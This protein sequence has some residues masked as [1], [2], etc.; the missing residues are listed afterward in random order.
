[1]FSRR[2][3]DVLVG[4]GYIDEEGRSLALARAGE[5]GTPFGRACVELGLVTPST[6]WQALA[7]QV[8]GNPIQLDGRDIDP[9]VL[10]L[11]PAAIALKHRCV[12]VGVRTDIGRGMLLVAVDGPRSAKALEEITFAAGR[13]V[14]LL[15][16]PEE[17]LERTLERCYAPRSVAY[18]ARG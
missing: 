5:S 8:G 18:N 6:L 2:I 4:H 7:L 9:S 17:A 12:P 3:G 14:M 11:L 15:V 16:A 10:T 13:R 1:M